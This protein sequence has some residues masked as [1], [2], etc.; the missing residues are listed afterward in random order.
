MKTLTASIIVIAC[1]LTACVA[2]NGYGYRDPG[3]SYVEQR[4]YG[5]SFGGATWYR[6]EVPYYPN[7]QNY[8]RNRNGIPDNREIDRNRNGIP[9]NR[10]VDRNR[11]GIP[12]TREV[13]RNHNGIPDRKEYDRDKDGKPDRKDPHPNWNT[14]PT[15]QNQSNDKFRD[16]Y[17]KPD[18]NGDSPNNN[19]G[20]NYGR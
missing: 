12:D 2:D 7:N 1:S 17:K 15:R 10:E 9:D 11:N 6:E 8:D 16:G 5:T 13:D 3:G 4:S 18:Y 14:G 20:N 19:Y